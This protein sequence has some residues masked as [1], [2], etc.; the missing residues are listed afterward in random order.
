VPDEVDARATSCDA[1][2][3]AVI[4]HDPVADRAGRE[5]RI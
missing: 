4:V 3:P 1:R 2:E 5:G